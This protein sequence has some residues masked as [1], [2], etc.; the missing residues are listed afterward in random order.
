MMSPDGA[1][2]GNKAFCL[3]MTHLAPTFGRM[4]F[5]R[6]SCC[7][8]IFCKLINLFYK[9]QIYLPVYKIFLPLSK[10]LCDCIRCIHRIRC[11]HCIKCIK[12]VF[13]FFIGEDRGSDNQA[14]FRILLQFI[15]ILNMDKRKKSSRLGRLVFDDDLPEDSVSTEAFPYD[16]TVAPSV[17]EDS[18]CVSDVDEYPS[19]MV[20]VDVMSQKE[21]REKERVS[22]ARSKGSKNRKSRAAK[23]PAVQKQHQLRISDYCFIRLK[24][25]M[26]AMSLRMSGKFISFDEMIRAL[27]EHWE[28]R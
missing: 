11:I 7:A 27:L 8:I 21:P 5:A 22:S 23:V 17:H 12:Y 1:S 14:R 15:I 9:E 19:D 13:I 20:F 18:A 28:K 3:T 25:E 24:E 6:A 26:S 4:S 2:L 10:N 16:E